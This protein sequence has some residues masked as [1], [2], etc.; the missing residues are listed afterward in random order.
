VLPTSSEQMAQLIRSD[1]A[2]WVPLIKNLGI[3]VD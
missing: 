3:S 1:Q 2:F